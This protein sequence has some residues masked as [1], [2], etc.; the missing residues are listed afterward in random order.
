MTFK[1]NS[2][3]VFESV[4]SYGLDS[5]IVKSL[6]TPERK[7]WLNNSSKIKISISSIKQRYSLAKTKSTPY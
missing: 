5:Q 7:N 1:V 3:K 2:N 6:Y 4:L